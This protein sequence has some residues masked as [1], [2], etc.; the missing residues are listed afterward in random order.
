MFFSFG[1]LIAQNELYERTFEGYAHYTFSE[2]GITCKENEGFIDLNEYFVLHK[3]SENKDSHAGFIYGPIF[4]SKDEH[5]LV[6]YP[7]LLTYI[8]KEQQEM[9][10][11]AAMITRK[12][13]NDTTTAE[14]KV[15]NN[16]TYSRSQVTGELKAA[17]GLFDYYGRPFHDS[18]SFDFNEHVTIIAGRHTREMFN[19]DT[20]YIYDLPMKSPY[21]KQYTHRTGLVLS[22]KDRATMAFKLFFTEEGKKREEEYIMLLSGKVWYEEEFQHVE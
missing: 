18:V 3:I 19:A 16:D 21:Q 5:C 9:D 11:R 8:S 10:K 12:L 20:M 7:G 6:M 1:Q 15:G 13:N 22:R 4:Q 2:F 14:P 17:I